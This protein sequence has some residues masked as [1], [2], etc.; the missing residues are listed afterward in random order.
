MLKYNISIVGLGYVGLPLLIAF[1]K[2]YNVI[3][4][5]ID[6]KRIDE[7]NQNFDKTKEISANQVK[8][9]KNKIKF[10]S[11]YSDLI[12]SNIIIVTLPTPI[13]KNKKPNLNIIKKSCE[14][15][16]KYLNKNDI[17]IFE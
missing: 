6:K 5:D 17:I 4:I 14:K 7:L 1:A 3:G 13:F 16:S 15:I 11:N 2:K 12:N 8:T 9:N 10:T